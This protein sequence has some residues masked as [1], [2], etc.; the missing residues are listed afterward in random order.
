MTLA[1]LEPEAL[2]LDPDARARLA[3]TLLESLEEPPGTEI[4]A[5]WYDEAERRDREL[6]EGRV[7][8]IPAEEV[9]AELKSGR[10]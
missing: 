5:L 8:A 3:A 9:L 6:D 1:D 10:K 4:E 7:T 2:K